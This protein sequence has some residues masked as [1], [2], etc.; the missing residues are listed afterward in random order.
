MYSKLR[1]CLVSAAIVLAAKTGISQ[2]VRHQ[3]DSLQQLIGDA[4]DSLKL[5]IELELFRLN[6]GE[7]KKDAEQHAREALKIATRLNDTLSI[8]KSYN[9]IGF[10]KKDLGYPRLAITFFEDALKLARVNNYRRQIKFLLNNL[11]LSNQ[12]TANY[13]KALEYHLESL[14]LREEDKD[15]ISISVC[16]N[17]IGV[18]YQE[19]GDY[20]NAHTYYK[21]NY[22]IK[23]RAKEYYDFELCLTNLADVSNALGKYDQAKSYLQQVFNRCSTTSKCSEKQLALA[24]Q[25]MGYSYM[26]TGSLSEAETEFSLAASLFSEIQSPDKIDSYRA[27]ALV[28]YKMNDYDGALDK[29]EIAQS[30]ASA[31]EI[32]KY[33]LLNYQLYADIYDKKGD[34]RK[35]SEFQKKFIS[36]NDEI[37]NADLIKNIARVQS[38]HLEEQNLRTIAQQ[39]QE[40]SNQE[41]SLYQQRLQF[42]FLGLI[43]SLVFIAAVVFYRKERKQIRTNLELEKAK[44]TIEEQNKELVSSNVELDNR[45]KE[46]TKELYSTN[47]ALKKVNEELDNFIYKTSHDI[48]GPL[49]SL[50]GITNIAIKEVKD[51]TIMSYL[52]KLDLTAEK[53]NKILTRLQIIN[54]INHALLVP[55][56]IDFNSMVDDILT[57]EKRKGMP[58]DLT[59]KTNIE[60]GII[61]FSDKAILKLVLENLVDNAIKFNDPSNRKNSFVNIEIQNQDDGVTIKVTDNGIGFK[62]VTPDHVFKMF[63]RASERSESGGIGMYLTKLSTEKLGGSIQLSNTDEE[64]TEF[65][66]ALPSDLRLVIKQR[67][68]LEQRIQV[69]KLVMAQIQMEASSSSTQTQ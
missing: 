30:M 15:T 29:L 59:I 40:I 16:L 11:G 62:N 18:L 28:R 60:H 46:R 44:L 61:V 63:I 64:L 21:R 13:A 19:M 23:T 10:V 17:N 38:E 50:K 31:Y 48:R 37:Y 6:L 12:K 22:D 14:K 66:V 47:E 33:L 53:L 54:Q 45:V 7:D 3:I 51:E 57:T 24:H 52:Q 67:D 56:L 43:A 55:E 41:L 68:E 4:S 32:P 8:V 5:E 36:L 2:N 49:S 34:F 69:E 58:T 26:E 20:E 42:M 39:D 27:L 25:A 65:T 35:A 9:A 1:W